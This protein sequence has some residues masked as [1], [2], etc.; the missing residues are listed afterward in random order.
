[1]VFKDFDPQDSW[2]EAQYNEKLDGYLGDIKYN[3]LDDDDKTKIRGYLNDNKGNKFLSTELLYWRSIEVIKEVFSED[4]LKNYVTRQ[5]KE[6]DLNDKLLYNIGLM[7]IV[8][9]I[10]S[11]LKTKLTTNKTLL[12][13]EKLNWRSI[14]VIKKVFFE[15][16]LKTYATNQI[17]KGDLNGKLLYNIGQMNIVNAIKSELKEKLN[18]DTTSL[19]EWSYDEGVEVIKAVFSEDELKTYATNQIEKGD[20]NDDL[21]NNMYNIYYNKTLAIPDDVKNALKEKLNADKTLLSTE[22]LYWSNSFKVIKVVFSENE[23][24][25]YVKNQIRTGSLNNHLLYNIVCSY[26]SIPNDVKNIL[27]TKLNADKTLLT[28]E[29][30]YFDNIEVIKAV[31]SNGNDFETYVKNQIQEVDLNGKLLYNIGQMNIVNAIKS[32]LKEKLNTDETLLST[33]ELYS[34]STEV[35]KVLFSE[36]ELKD[37]VK[38]QIS[39]DYLNDKLLHNI[40]LMNIV[41]AIKSDLKTKLTT[42]KTLLSIEKLN[43]R[44][45]EVIKKVFFEDELKTYATNQIEKG[46]L[47]GKLLYNIGQMNI[48]N[49]IKSELKEK[50]NADKTLLSIEKLDWES[51]TVIKEVFSGEA[52]KV[53]VTKQVNQGDLN[54]N[55]LLNIRLIYPNGTDIPDDVKNALKTKLKND[56]TLLS[57]WLH[58]D[59]IEVIKVVLGDQLNTYVTNQIENGDLNYELLYNIYNIYYSNNNIL[60]IPDDVKEILKT[61]LTD[62]KTLLNTENLYSDSIKVIKEVFSGNGE[63]KDYVLNR[64]DNAKV[65]N[66]TRLWEVKWEIPYYKIWTSCNYYEVYRK[67]ATL[68]G[69]FD[70]DSKMPEIYF[71]LKT[72]LILGVIAGIIVGIVKGV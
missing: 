30:L 23:L 18:A 41:N 65:Y 22:E 69:K 61:K 56:T 42:N 32:E 21:I 16:E 26:S 66:L 68:R 24:K 31:F 1:M 29:N 11:D 5:I 34:E 50:L 4:E 67:L 6:G 19:S 70:S 58:L 44:S 53:Y 28:T 17:E 54:N 15:D 33:K 25:T 60:D 72:V 71:G 64:F 36:D 63:L 20:L 45:I 35:I 52:L 2:T 38:N 48:V 12:S 3:S 47:N 10:K 51:L 43:W 7:N 14:E 57:K 49:A 37:Y 59:I 62:D 55:L 40:G 13:I 8:N 9:A 39:Q 46:D 27:K